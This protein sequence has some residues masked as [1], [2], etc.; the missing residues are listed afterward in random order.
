MH[1]G[2]IKLQKQLF[3]SLT[4]ASF[5]CIGNI[6]LSS[7]KFVYMNIDLNNKNKFAEKI[8][9]FW[10]ITKNITT[11]RDNQYTSTVDCVKLDKPK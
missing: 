3:D 2:T 1:Y 10:Y 8:P 4:K 7:N 9:G 6:D 5:T 11:I